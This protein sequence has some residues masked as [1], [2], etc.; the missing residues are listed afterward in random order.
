MQ[1]RLLSMR[2]TTVRTE[3]DAPP[4]IVSAL[5]TIDPDA[6]LVLLRPAKKGE[7]GRGVWILGAV[8]PDS[9]RREAAG[10]MLAR[11]ERRPERLRDP[12]EIRFWQ[13][14]RQG[15]RQVQMY[16][17][18]VENLDLVVA[19]F[20]ERDFNYRTKLEEILRE[21]EL[22]LDGTRGAERAEKNMLDRA[23]ALARD[24]QAIVF[25]KRISARVDGL[26]GAREAP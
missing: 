21:T 15:F 5:R 20:R 14:V 7:K 17:L 23:R 25:R 18:D 9:R 19:D 26:R 4:H 24:I 8:K 3:Q 10:R 6:E 1:D 12:A 11:F 13:L 2:L 22:E 16:R